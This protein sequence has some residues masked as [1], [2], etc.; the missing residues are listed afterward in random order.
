MRVVTG[1]NSVDL[2]VTEATPTISFTDFSRRVTDDFGVTTVVQRG[3]SRKLSVRMMVPFEDASALQQRLADLRATS[4]SWIADDS[5]QWLQVEGFYKDFDIDL[6]NPPVS[7]CTLSVEGLAETSTAPDPGGDPAPEGSASTLELL[8][9]VVIDDTSLVASSVGESDAATWAAGTTYAKGQR[10]VHA[11]RAWESL[12]A[13]NV[14]QEPG[15]ASTVWLDTGPTNRWAMFD[16]ALGTATQADTV[17][18]VTVEAGPIDAIALLDVFAAT[19]RVQAAGY[20]RTLAA[21]AGAIVFRDLTGVTGQITVTVTGDHVA[22]G[23]ALFGK[24]ATLGVTGASPTAGIID[25]SRKAV[26]DFGEVTIVQ[27]GW[28][29]RMQEQALIRT[30]A[31]DMV[32]NR[33]AA[34][35]ATPCLWIGQDGVAALTIYGFFKDFSIARGEAVSTLSL[36]VE[37]L[38]AASPVAA[39]VN[40][41]DIGDPD[42]TKPANNADVTGD[43]TAK[44][45]GAVAGVPAATVTDAIK[46][47]SGVVQP[48]R[49]QIAAVK[50]GL[51]A[52]MAAAVL[53]I[54]MLSGQ[55]TTDFT[56]LNQEVDGLTAQAT[57]VQGSIATLQNTAAD[58]G[59]E[60]NSLQTLTATH[61]ASI[62]TNAQAITAAN[63]SLATLNTIVTA[64]SNPNLVPNGGF[65]NG[66]AGWVRYGPQQWYPN[67]W[68]WG[69]HAHCEPYN[70]TTG[71]DI[72]NVIGTDNIGVGGG[73]WYA[74]SFDCDVY[75]GGGSGLYGSVAWYD[76]NGTYIG[77]SNSPFITEKSFDVTGNSRIKLIMTAPANATM[78]RV[79]T[80][81]KYAAGTNN[82]NPPYVRAIKFEAGNICTPYSGEATAGQM[83]QAYA[84]LNSSFASLST[85]VSSQG[86]SINTLLSTTTTLSGTVS[87]LSTTVSAQGGSIT[88]LQSVQSTHSGQIATL[89][90]DLATANAGV[91]QNAQA[92]SA[93][94]GN[95]ASL[96]STVQAQGGSI[97]SLQQIQGT[98]SGQIATLNQR[99]ALGGNVLQNTD[100]AVDR[101]AWNVYYW[102]AGDSDFEYGRDWAGDNWRP[103]NE[104]NLGVHQKDADGGRGFQFFT[105][106]VAVVA[107]KWYEFSAWTATHRCYSELRFDWYDQNNNAIGSSWSGRSDLLPGFYQSNGGSNLKDWQR[108]WVKAQVPANAKFC[109]CVVLKYATSQDGGWA[110][111]GDSYMWFVRPQLAEVYAETVGPVGYTPGGSRAVLDNQQT[112]INS[113]NGQLASVSSTVATQGASITSN[114]QALSTLNSQYASLSSTVTAQGSSIT[115]NAQAI[116]TLNGQMASLS[117]QVSTQGV[118]VTANAQAISGLNGSVAALQGRWGV[119]IDANGYVSGF[120]L[121]NNGSRSDF[122]IRADKFSVV[123]PN[124]AGFSII[125]GVTRTVTGGRRLMQG[126]GVGSQGNL[127]LWYGP[128]STAIGAETV[129]N[130]NFAIATDGKVYYGQAEIGNSTAAQSVFSRDF[131]IGGAGTF[132]SNP[133]IVTPDYGVVNLELETNAFNAANQTF[134][135][136]VQIQQSSDGSNWSNIGSAVSGTTNQAGEQKFG[137]A[138]ATGLSASKTYF[139]ALVTIDGP[140]GGTQS[141]NVNGTLTAS[142]G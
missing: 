2:G 125:G 60:I 118:T 48:A 105:E 120:A 71:Q 27:R 58:Q 47:G 126:P 7:F 96:S 9:P 34:V 30:D 134:H 39:L 91:S 29:K 107:G 102:N 40:W 73:W 141:A 122:A 5:L 112:A 25:Y 23:T 78:A 3:F 142:L 74:L 64:S 61:G 117:S 37:G 89:S 65:E 44:D 28:A 128:D 98:Q 36:S 110:G 46:N 35:R 19:V 123:D 16:Q 42:G 108:L 101:S 38:S 51:D 76:S 45:T 124:G 20:D 90:T 13:G 68:S 50:A 139:R 109:Y 136:S 21:T 135:Y 56:S 93:T 94:N 72:Y 84:D 79:R 82:A 70:N 77:E 66:L 83:Y 97:T 115:T 63:Q 18:S 6:N 111:A 43:N 55:V 59:A 88:S 129:A 130:S 81:V 138:S 95:L 87:S 24:L 75:L 1:G 17:V 119:E 99:V 31:I 53:S 57:A 49:D 103:T 54:G 121:N 106:Q 62:A 14:G 137:G 22:I 52:A 131:A 140:T 69:Y 32:A 26:D 85:T 86:G 100:F 15:D 113:V 8:Q 11:H 127:V 114:A 67:N 132:G 33:I 116:S 92:I 80:V 10:V 104:H 4:A 12:I 41:P 133:V